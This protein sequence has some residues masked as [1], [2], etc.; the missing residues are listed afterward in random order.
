MCTSVII[1]VT[2]I[3]ILLFNYWPRCNG[4]LPMESFWL[5]SAPFS[6]SSLTDK[7]TTTTMTHLLA[8]YP[9]RPGRA[10]NR[11]TFTHSLSLS[12]S[13]NMF[14]LTFSIYYTTYTA[15]SLHSCWIWQSF[16]TTSVQLFF[17]PSLLP[18]PFTPKSMHFSRDH[19]CPFFKHVHTI[20]TY[21]AVQL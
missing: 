16:S 20:S 4:V 2:I 14:Q 15:Y 19:S 9:G 8:P 12:G 3:I 6:S 18:A 17:G 21:F 11:K 10:C 5:V 7:S 1:F 13:Y